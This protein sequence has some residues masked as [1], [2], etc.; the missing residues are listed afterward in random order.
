[1]TTNEQYSFL[2]AALEQLVGKRCPYSVPMYS[3]LELNGSDE[4]TKIQDW[5]ADNAKPPWATGLSMLEAAEL[6]VSLAIENGNI[7]YS[8]ADAIK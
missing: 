7:V 8:S 5:C 1:M 4:V 3:F 6:I 2:R